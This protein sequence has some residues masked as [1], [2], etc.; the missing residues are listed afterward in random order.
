[1]LRNGLITTWARFEENV[2]N[3]FGL[4]KYEDPHGALSKLL[5]L[6]TVEDYQ[7]EFEKL[8]NS[9][10]DIPDSLLISYYISGLKLNL[11][12]E[13]LVSRLTTLDDAFSLARI[14]EAHFEAIAKKEKVQIVKKKTDAILPLQSELASSKIKDNKKSVEEVEGGGEAL[15][16]GEDDDSSNAATDGGDDA[17]KS[18]DISIINSLIGLG[19]PRSPQLCVSKA[20]KSLI[21]SSEFIVDHNATC[22]TR[23]QHHVLVSYVDFERKYVSIVDDE[24]FKQ[25]MLSPSLKSVRRIVGSSQGLFCFFYIRYK[26]CYANPGDSKTTNMARFWNPT[27]RKSVDIVVP[28][29]L[30]NARFQ[31]VVGFGVCPNTCDPML[32]KITFTCSLPSES[33]TIHTQVEA[34]DRI[35]YMDDKLQSY[36]LI[37]SFNMISR[38]FTELYLPHNLALKR[39]DIGFHISKRS[40]SLVVIQCKIE[41]DKRVYGVW[42][43]NNGNPK[44]FTNLFTIN[45]SHE[46]ILK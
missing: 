10:T 5:Q 40:E 18:R 2:K 15:G 1:M 30:E 36:N 27:I 16:V 14:I 34:Y 31:T 35:N 4:S 45:P 41:A 7:R 26:D 8:M 37:M 24:I 33:E 44:S 43:M 9:V 12:H 6:G 11:Q 3:R 32:V 39:S 29:V 21:D 28:R 23:R 25:Q 19:S 42:M 38:E 20:W 13:L 22:H 17:V 46:S